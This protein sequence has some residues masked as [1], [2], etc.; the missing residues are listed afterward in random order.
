MEQDYLLFRKI[1]KVA[2]ITVGCVGTVYLLYALSQRIYDIGRNDGIIE[3]QIKVHDQLAKIKNLRN[4]ARS[5]LN[6]AKSTF[7]EAENLRR[8][9]SLHLDEAK[10]LHH[11]ISSTTSST[12]NQLNLL[13]SL[14]VIFIHFMLNYHK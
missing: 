4:E 11:N 1:V 3:E 5:S 2:A 7:E 9:A 8:A 12:T 10:E 6:E 13:N 14:Q